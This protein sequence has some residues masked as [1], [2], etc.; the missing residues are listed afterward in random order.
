MPK[1][2]GEPRFTGIIHGGDVAEGTGEVIKFSLY[3]YWVFPPCPI[4]EIDD[5]E[6]SAEMWLGLNVKWSALWWLLCLV[7]CIGEGMLVPVLL[8]PLEFTLPFWCWLRSLMLFCED[9][10]VGDVKEWWRNDWWGCE[11]GR[12]GDAEAPFK[13]GEFC[14]PLE[15]QD[16]LMLDPLWFKCHKGL[17]LGLSPSKFSRMDS[18]G[19]PTKQLYKFD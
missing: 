1:R 19:G 9:I 2:A 12:W 8:M 4:Y 15:E 13:Q 16:V 5:A 11:L 7:W 3:G 18:G 10:E 17:E 14:I 6:D